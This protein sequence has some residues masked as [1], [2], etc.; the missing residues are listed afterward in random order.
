[1]VAF[2]RT[3]TIEQ[4]I[5]VGGGKGG[6]GGEGQGREGGGESEI[7]EVGAGEQEKSYQ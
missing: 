7:E 2:S 6:T 4:I 5:F 3:R 1:M